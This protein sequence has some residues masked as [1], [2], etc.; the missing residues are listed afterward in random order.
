MGALARLVGGGNSRIL[1]CGD[2][3]V[4]PF[5]RFRGEILRSSLCWLYLPMVLSELLLDL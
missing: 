5:L 4:Y 3:H 2:T 1:R